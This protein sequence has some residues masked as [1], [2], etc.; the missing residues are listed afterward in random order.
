MRNA[1]PHKLLIADIKLNSGLVHPKSFPPRRRVWK[2]KE[3]EVCAEYRHQEKFVN[4]TLQNDIEDT[5]KEL[6][7]CI[8]NSFD[9]CCDWSN[10]KQSRREI[11]QWNNE[12]DFA[13][14]EKR[15]L[16]KKMVQE[17]RT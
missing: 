1:H 13:I 5:W 2:L 3:P 14:K 6:K 8:L 12:V 4:L 16:W 9:V 15:K 17:N 10:P 11:W 7:A